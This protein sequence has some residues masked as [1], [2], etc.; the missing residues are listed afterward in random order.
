MVTALL[1]AREE[2][3][4]EW[5]RLDITTPHWPKVPLC[6]RAM[7]RLR[8]TAKAREEAPQMRVSPSGTRTTYVLAQRP[9]EWWRAGR[10]REGE[11]FSVGVVLGLRRMHVERE[12]VV[13]KL[14]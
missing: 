8:A 10:R 7:E 3:R 13:S 12:Y 1:D 6:E 14:C 5:L 9:R 2:P 11:G 4:G